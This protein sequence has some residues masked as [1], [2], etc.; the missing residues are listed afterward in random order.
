VELPHPMQ[1]VVVGREPVRVPGWRPT[2]AAVWADGQRPELVEGEHP[3]RG[4]GHDMFDPGQFGFLGRVVG[5]LPRLGPLEGE[6]VSAQQL[7]ESFPTD[8][9]AV[10][11][12]VVGEVVDEFPDPPAGERLTEGFGSGV[13]RPDDER[14]VVFT[15]QAGTATRS[16]RVQLA[17]HA[18]LVEPVDDPADRV[19]IGLHETGDHRH[20]VATGRGEHDHRPAQPD[21]RAGPSSG[22]S[23]QLLTFL[24]R[25]PPHTHGF[26]QP[27]SLTADTPPDRE[28][29]R[30][31]IQHRE[32]LWSEH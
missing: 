28:V 20:R 10:G 25:Q 14:F 30:R 27:P 26:C 16:P 19:L 32:R 23:E 7:A 13:S 15:D 24:V 4:G 2:R 8:L 12:V 5:L 17:G 9:D 31:V 6:V 29:E 3:V 1:L 18:H 11:T 22:D 21:R